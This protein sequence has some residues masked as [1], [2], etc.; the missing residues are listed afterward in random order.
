MSALRIETVDSDIDNPVPAEDQAAA[1]VYYC[2]NLRTGCMF[3]VCFTIVQK[4]ANLIYVFFSVTPFE[5]KRY[6][7]KFHKNVLHPLRRLSYNR[8]QQM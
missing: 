5:N 4:L 2:Q 7:K 8:L 6:D 1:V 3:Y